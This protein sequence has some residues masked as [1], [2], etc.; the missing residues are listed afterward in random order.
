MFIKKRKVTIK[1]VKENLPKEY[2]L[3]DVSNFP[4]I[5]VQHNCG[6]N[7]VVDYRRVHTLQCNCEEKIREIKREK[8]DNSL[9]YEEIKKREEEQ[10]NGKQVRTNIDKSKINVWTKRLREEELRNTIVNREVLGVVIEFHKVSKMHNTLVCCI[11][12]YGNGDK[13]KEYVDIRIFKR[14][15][16]NETVYKSNIRQQLYTYATYLY[17][18]LTYDKKTTLKL[19]GGYYGIIPISCFCVNSNLKLN[20]RVPNNDFDA[21]NLLD[22]IASPYTF[23][24]NLKYFYKGLSNKYEVEECIIKI[25]EDTV[26]Q[27]LVNLNIGFDRQP[28]NIKFKSRN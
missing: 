14:Y 9:T 13:V 15:N 12:E 26:N 16:R 27:L 6:K 7:I 4:I 28:N 19:R 21:C 24:T 17:I 11:H 1:E 8:Y 18:N 22:Y 20:L 10:K 25:D 23:C 2:V 5:T 3:I